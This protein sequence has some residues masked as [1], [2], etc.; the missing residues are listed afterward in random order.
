MLPTE[1]FWKVC[2]YTVLVLLG[3]YVSI[4]E[5]CALGLSNSISLLLPFRLQALLSVH[6]VMLEP[7]CKNC[8]IAC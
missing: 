4:N 6:P 1:S 2:V 7:P 8:L 5:K 3:L